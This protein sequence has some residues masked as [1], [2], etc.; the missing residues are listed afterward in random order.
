MIK[1]GTLVRLNPTFFSITF[2]GNPRKD[3]V[4]I[5]IR[6][7]KEFYPATTVSHSP[8]DRHYI[9]WG[10][11]TYSYEPTRALVEVISSDD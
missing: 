6:S 11:E 10:N 3:S 9:L 4:G 7:E 2:A 5:V 8:Q 1:P